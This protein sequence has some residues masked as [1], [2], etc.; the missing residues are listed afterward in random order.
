M[1]LG[2]SVTLRFCFFFNDPATTEI[3]TLPLHDALPISQSLMLLNITVAPVAPAI[4]T[5]AGSLIGKVATW[6]GRTG[7]TPASD[8][9]STRLNSSHGYISYAVFC[10]KKTRSK[11]A[12]I[13]DERAMPTP[14]S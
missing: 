7:P 6:P 5:P 11:S 8:R 2:E 13:T 14:L 4:L 1:S 12:K 3:Y 9:K 10:L